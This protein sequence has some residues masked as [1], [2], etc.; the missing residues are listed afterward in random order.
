MSVKLKDWVEKNRNKFTHSDLNFILKE[1]LSTS[2]YNASLDERNLTENQSNRLEE[3][4]LRYLQGVP[5]GY[6]LGKEEFFGLDFFVSKDVLIPRPETELIVE[7]SLEYI[8]R[9]KIKNVL[10]L[11]CGCANISVAVALNTKKEISLF[12]SDISEEAL[13]VSK[14]NIDAHKCKIKLIKSDLLSSFKNNSFDLIISNPPYVEDLFRN[15]QKLKYEPEKALFAGEKGIDFA[16][17]IIDQARQNLTDKGVL[18]MEIGFG[19][20]DLV[21]NIVDN[22]KTCKIEEWIKDY[23][24]H[25]RG[26]VIR[27]G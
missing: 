16:E 19:H 22:K 9:E 20:K 3:I 1:F 13:A 2:I 23:Q 10:D 6:I 27:Y 24:G 14:R 8:N 21:K 7:K 17:K 25:F 18:I 12:A 26:V 15:D 11:C 4:I 5:V